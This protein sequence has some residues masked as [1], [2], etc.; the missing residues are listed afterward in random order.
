MRTIILPLVILAIPA[1]GLGQPLDPNFDRIGIYYDTA[2]TTQEASPGLYA[3][4]P[5]Y[6]CFTHVEETSGISGWEAHVTIEPWP[7]IPPTYTLLGEGAL[8]V[9]AA[10]DFVVGLATPLPAAPSIP[11]LEI[12]VTPLDET[13]T[14][15]YLDGADVS[16]FDGLPGYAAGDDP[17][18]LTACGVT[19]TCWGHVP[20]SA[21]MF[22]HCPLPGDRGSW[23]GVKSLYR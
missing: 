21:M 10:P 22:E 7:A 6:V 23:G 15:F 9:S 12:V 20:F 2:A 16:S 8:N 17:G 3:P 19:L 11:V 18:A 4:I 14:H 1:A 5:L 13:P